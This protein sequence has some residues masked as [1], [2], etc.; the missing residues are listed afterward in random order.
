MI[1]LEV[2]GMVCGG[3][4]EAVRRAIAARDPAASVVVDRPNGRVKAD[5]SLSAE[6]AAAAVSAAGYGAKPAA[7]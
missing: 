6:Q 3:C 1:E 7:R 2:T 4:A 5:T